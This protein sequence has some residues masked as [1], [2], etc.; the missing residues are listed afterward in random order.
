MQLLSNVDSSAVDL[1]LQP[2]TGLNTPVVR[3]NW[4]GQ[5]S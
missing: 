4:Q 5:L 2:G 3:S 1:A